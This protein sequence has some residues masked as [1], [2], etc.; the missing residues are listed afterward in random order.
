MSKHLPVALVID[1]EIQIRRFLRAGF[2]LENFAV[3]EAATAA[4]GLRAAT[5]KPIDLVVHRSRAA[6]HGWRQ[7][8]WSACAHGR[9][10]RSS[11]CRCDRA[12]MR[13][14]GCWSWAP[15]TTWSSRSAWPSCLRAPGPPC[16]ARR[17]GRP[18]SRS[19]ARGPLAIDLER[20]CTAQRVHRRRAASS[21]PRKSIAS[22]KLLAQ[23]AGN[24]VTHQH[25]LKEVW[26]VTHL[27]DAHYLRIFIRKIRKKIEKDP[28]QP[29]VLVTE[30]GAGYRL[31]Q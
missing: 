8:S 27:D 12:R 29:Q 1:D 4:D 31:A 5:L 13:R 15:T 10:Y 14:Y 22:C 30:L 6:R 25:L 20:P 17:E 11:S 23:H 26:G 19:C 28:T 24:V 16:G 2:E 3:Q 9:P 7:K 18:A 21:C